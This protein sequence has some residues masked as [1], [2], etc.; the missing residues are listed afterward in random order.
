MDNTGFAKDDIVFIYNLPDFVGFIGK[1][2]KITRAFND[3]SYFL[4]G[5]GSFVFYSDELLLVSRRGN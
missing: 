2:G 5:Y 3:G 1:I 4:E